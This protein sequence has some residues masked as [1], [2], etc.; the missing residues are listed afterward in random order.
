VSGLPQRCRAPIA[1][2]S[3]RV[4]LL[5]PRPGTGPSDSGMYSILRPVDDL[6]VVDLESGRTTT[7]TA[8]SRDDE[9]ADVVW[10]GDGSTLFFR[11]IDQATY[12][13][14]IRRWQP[15]M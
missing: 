5:C 6:V 4:A 10:S 15:G 9:L 14:S 7:L 11:A 3:S 1:N 12:A 13:E 2:A 8:A